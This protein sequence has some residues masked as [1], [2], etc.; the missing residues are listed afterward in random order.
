MLLAALPAEETETER[1][2]SLPLRRPLLSRCLLTGA[3]VL[4]PLELCLSSGTIMSM[5]PSR[6]EKT[7][8]ASEEDPW[9]ILL[10]GLSTANKNQ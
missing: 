4:L 6:A 8:L 2:L 10:S 7:E 9:V 5:G 3:E 1:A